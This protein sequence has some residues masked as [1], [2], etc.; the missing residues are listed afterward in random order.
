M[1]W[2]ILF[3][4]RYKAVPE[5]HIITILILLNSETNESLQPTYNL[6]ENFHHRHSSS[7]PET[8][9]DSIQNN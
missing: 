2:L 1:G 5:G 7:D 9:S 6:Y 4:D 8:C 3:R